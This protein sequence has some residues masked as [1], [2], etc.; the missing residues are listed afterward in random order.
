MKLRNTAIAAVLSLIPVGQPLVIG[1]GAAL[2]TTA[3]MLAVPEK[4]KAESAVFYFTLAQKKWKSRDFYGAI[5]DF[6]KSIEIEPNN[7]KS[8]LSIC[9]VK[10]MF[11]MNEEAI[12][13]VNDSLNLSNIE[14]EVEEE[15]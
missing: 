10:V 8:Y 3:V 13:E 12:D 15:A 2:T 5:S 14:F 4:A 11:G 6:K 1:R 7:P 9:G